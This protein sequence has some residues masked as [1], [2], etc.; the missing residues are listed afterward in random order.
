MKSFAEGIGLALLAIF[1]FVVGL[2]GMVLLIAAPLAALG[3]GAAI[4]YRIFC[5][6]VGIPT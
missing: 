3:A 4:A 2:V 5:W 1:A 6:I